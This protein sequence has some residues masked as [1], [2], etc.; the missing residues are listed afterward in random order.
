MVNDVAFSQD[1]KLAL[2]ASDDY[3]L[4]LWDVGTGVQVRKMDDGTLAATGIA[5]LPDGKQ[6]L[7]TGM[8][9]G[10]NINGIIDTKSTR[11]WDVSTG[12]MVDAF[13]TGYLGSY[14]DVKARIAFSPDGKHALVGSRGNGGWVF[15]IFSHRWVCGFNGD[16]VGAVY[17]VAFSKDGKY[18]L[19]GGRDKTARLWDFLMCRELRVFT[20]GRS[21]VLSVAFSPDS[22]YILTG[23]NDNTARLWD[24]STV[25]LI[26]QFTGHMGW[27]NSAVFTPDG[28]FVVTGSQDG[29]VRIWDTDYYDTIAFAC[30]VLWRDLSEQERS[31]YGITD[32]TPTC[33]E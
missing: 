33:P 24:A 6:F 26:R 20:D 1:G 7:S 31:Q 3:T 15:N 30:S 21:L 8:G 13:N 4:R 29:T 23:H 28:R 12:G 25:A 11:L 32:D 10:S 16:N 19:T 2:T 17:S 5:F 14:G 9:G 27:I 22:K 18:A